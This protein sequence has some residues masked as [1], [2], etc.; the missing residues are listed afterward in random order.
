M[1]FSFRDTYSIIIRKK[2]CLKYHD[3]LKDG[4]LKTAR[5]KQKRRKRENFT[6][7]QS[8]A[9]KC[10]CFSDLRARGHKFR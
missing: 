8:R 3:K 1:L 6:A 7:E 2:I 9:W 4:P 5:T 10:S